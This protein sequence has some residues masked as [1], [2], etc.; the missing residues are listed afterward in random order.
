MIPISEH[1][2]D[3]PYQVATTTD[4]SLPFRKWN[5]RGTFYA[6]THLSAA[7]KALTDEDGTVDEADTT[8]HPGIVFRT[9]SGL[10]FHVHL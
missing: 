8:V 3:R 6:P 1:L 10:Y 7:F 9:S 2:H 5:H 4:P